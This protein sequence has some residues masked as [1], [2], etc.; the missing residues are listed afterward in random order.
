MAKQSIRLP[1]SST[2]TQV[3][4][5]LD[6]AGV[7]L[8][9]EAQVSQIQQALVN[10]LHWVQGKDEQFA[11][12]HDYYTALAHSVRNQLLKKRIRTAKTYAQAQAKNVYYLS[13]E[14][15]M[16]RQLGNGLINLGLYDTMRHALAD[17]GLDLDELLE[18]EAEPGL[19]NGGLGRLAACF[20][21]SLTTL[22][23]PAIGYGIRYEFGIFTQLIR[24]GHQVEAP[25]KWLSYGNPWEI[26]RPDYRVEI[27][28]GGHTEVYKKDGDDDYQVRWIPAQTV[29]GIP[30]DVPVPGYG[31]ENV[32]LLRL[33]KAEAGEAFDLDAFNAGDYFGAVANKMISENITKVLYPND[34]TRQGKEL[35]L[36]QQYFFVACSLQDIIRLHLRDHSNL[37]NLA[38]FAAIQ[39]NDTHPAIG[40]AE[41]MRLLIDE[42]DFEWAAAWNITQRTFG[43]TNHTLMPEALE[44]WSVDLFGKLLPRHLEII[45]EINHR[46]LAQVKL[47]YPNDPDRLE[48]LSLIEEG[49]ERRVRMANLA[50]VGSHAINGVAALHTE[51]L[52][53]EVL[54]DFYELWPDK[55]SNKTNG[56]TP[57]RWLLQCNPRLAQLIS[58]TIGDRWITDL[59]RLRDL[60][61]HIDN[62]EFRRAWQAIKQENKWSLARYIH[63][64]V[65]IEVNPDS[66][67]DV[68]I[69]RIH[70][71]K[72][73]LMNVLH[74]I[75]LY[76]R[77]VQNPGDH[78][79]PRTVIF[80]GKAA[81]G[82][83]MAKLVVKLVN[84][85]ADVVNNDPIV[86][87]R[88]KVVFLPNYNVSQAQRLFPASDLSEQI[89]T[90]GMEASGTGNMKFAL[91]GALTIGTLDGANVEIRE[92]VGADNFFL[93]GLT[94]EQVAACKAVG[95]NPWYYYDTNP[96]L[97]RTLDVIASGLFSPGEPNLFLPILDSLLV[98]D[99][100]MVMADFA[101]Y[102][103]CQE[104]VSRTYEDRDRWVRMAILNTARIG[105]FSADRTIADYARE[106][107]KVK[108][109]PVAGE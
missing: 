49:S 39:L 34:E 86:A 80:G 28:F 66:M 81:P 21:D 72:R 104:H 77:M 70:E 89:S 52:K 99:P 82:Y 15:L 13:A 31:T 7:A 67:F 68:Q 5:S 46:F 32:N 65:G 98:D 62:D 56:I 96:E 20:M 36:Q 18:R 76:N 87:G 50:C 9:A 40:V 35:R 108:A 71:Y 43:Y 25:D 6:S 93:F 63:D 29:I 33:W 4:L 109:V 51:L 37:E 1:E 64:A 90:A 26:A 8:D 55:F 97:K 44:K 105:K 14:F 16:G 48:R 95:H 85:V 69:K 54:Q 24:Q 3:P 41:L 23:L 92:E 106:I 42:Y 11:N 58:E 107:W 94:T 103:Q 100:Y 102:V 75:T 91:N 47:R 53:Q 10:N 22:N 61:A 12:A 78:V 57:R 19:G 74:V 17:C 45:Y 79:V 59:D 38:E 88:L 2:T 83:A 60:E 101:A 30:H 73:Q 27:K 84:A